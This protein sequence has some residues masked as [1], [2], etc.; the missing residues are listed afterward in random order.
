MKDKVSPDVR[1][2]L[3]VKAKRNNKR[4]RSTKDV[5][6]RKSWADDLYGSA[7][8]TKEELLQDERLQ[9]LV[10]RVSTKPT[11]K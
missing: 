2:K 7:H 10:E 1:R 11:R 5:P 9:D 8:F 6:A 3:V 4:T